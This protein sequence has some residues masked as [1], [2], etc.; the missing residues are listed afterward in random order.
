MG[1][2]SKKN[3]NCRRAASRRRHRHVCDEKK[4][5]NI[6]N[7]NLFVIENTRRVAVRLVDDVSV[8]QF[9]ELLNKRHVKITGDQLTNGYTGKLLGQRALFSNLSD[10]KAAPDKSPLP[11]FD[12][13][14][15]YDFDY[16]QI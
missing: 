8:E 9:V 15:P 12:A 1:R 6:E 14:D 10:Y 4:V 2:L 5:S 7:Q 13:L 3:L 11:D 16:N